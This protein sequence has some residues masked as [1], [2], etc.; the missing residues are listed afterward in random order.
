MDDMKKL[1]ISILFVMLLCFIGMYNVKAAKKMSLNR[2]RVTDHAGNRVYL[3]LR[4][5]PKGRVTWSSSNKNYAVVEKAGKIL[6]K[7]PGKVTITAKCKKQTAKCS[8]NIGQPLRFNSYEIYVNQGK[9]RQLQVLNLFKGEKVKWGTFDTNVATVNRNGLVRANSPVDTYI[10]A[11]VGSRILKCYTTVIKPTQ[12]NV[13]KTMRMNTGDKMQLMI[14]RDTTDAHAKWQWSSSDPNV[15]SIDANGMVS[16]LNE[17]TVT[18]TAQKGTEKMSTTMV[19]ADPQI[20]FRQVGNGLQAYVKDAQLAVNWTTSDP[21]V[22]TIDGEGNLTAHKAGPVKVTGTINDVSGSYDLYISQSSLNHQPT[23]LYWSVSNNNILMMNKVLTTMQNYFTCTDYINYNICYKK[24]N[25]QDPTQL[26]VQSSDLTHG[27]VLDPNYYYQFKITRDDDACDQSSVPLK[28]GDTIC[29]D[30]CQTVKPIGLFKNYNRKGSSAHRGDEKKDP[31]N[32]TAAF[33]LAGKNKKYLSIESDLHDTKD[34]RFV[35]I[36]NNY[37]GRMTNIGSKNP[38]RMTPLSKLT[39]KEIRSYRIKWNGKVYKNLCVPTLE[40]YLD[41]CKKYKKIAR[42]DLKTINHSGSIQKIVDIIYKKKMQN[43]VVII[44]LDPGYIEN[45]CY[46]NKGAGLRKQVLLY[47]VLDRD[48][49]QLVLETGAASV[50]VFDRR[51]NTGA[52]KSWCKQHG[53]LFARWAFGGK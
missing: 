26:I 37:L 30:Q 25:S 48:T 35:M 33:I 41:I 5:V 4:N 18:I 29:V 32:T 11:Q 44:G 20:R 31:E 16:A 19:V 6:L 52:D 14:K 24:Y 46:A 53:I 3:K 17:G 21:N 27:V 15:V 45:F 22:A 38:H 49:R 36:H 42:I 28:A 34:G 9:T 12:L 50:S 43:Q 13:G 10:T 39:L 2:T 47:H 51:H 1:G 8:I 23:F 40:E 7:Q